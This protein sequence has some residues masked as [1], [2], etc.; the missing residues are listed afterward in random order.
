MATKKDLVEAYSFSRRRLVTAFVSGAPGGREVEPARPGRTIVGGVA[1]AVLLVAGAAIAGI[2]SPTTPSDWKKPGMIL[3]NDTG[4]LYVITEESDDPELLPV[5]NPT[6]AKL[7]LG[8]DATPTPIPQD[9]IGKQTLGE[10]VGIFSAPTALPEPEL[11]IDTGW[12]S[13]TADR[14]GIRTRIATEPDVTPAPGQ[15]ITVQNDGDFFVIAQSAPTG[16]GVPSAY[17]YRV[18]EQRGPGVDQTD[19]LLNALNVQTTG[20]AVQVSREWLSLFPTGAPLDFDSFTFTGFGKPSEIVDGADIGDLLVADGGDSYLVTDGGPVVLGD[21]EATVYANVITPDRTVPRTTSIVKSPGVGYGER[22][23]VLVDLQWPDDLPA[24]QL[25]G[26]PC[27]QLSA[28]HDEA[29]TVQLVSP[30]PESSGADVRRGV[31]DALVDVGHGAYVLSGSWRDTDQGSPV[32]ID[33]KGRV[34]P[35]I[36]DAATR[37]GYAD[38]PVAVVPDSWT[39]L[40]GCGVNLSL[41][42]A[43]SPPDPDSSESGCA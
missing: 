36:G 26:D 16:N 29:P 2:F 4:A 6:S 39:K 43:L 17:A 24:D 8:P 14:Q 19:D 41:D 30:G 38:V 15:A 9:V 37:L 1:L 25:T 28:V 21:F 7:I 22:D 12:T 20:E 18:P 35:L 31:K 40:F 23:K 10:E 33:S 27:A 34:N 3:S 13:C 42:A 5:L 11:L 32:V